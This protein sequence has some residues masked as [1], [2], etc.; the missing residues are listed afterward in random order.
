MSEAGFNMKVDVGGERVYNTEAVFNMEADSL[1]DADVGGGFN[2]GGGF[3]LHGGR[4]VFSFICKFCY[5][6]SSFVKKG[7]ST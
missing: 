7:E 5:S 3:V 4:I 2:H 1:M 6:V